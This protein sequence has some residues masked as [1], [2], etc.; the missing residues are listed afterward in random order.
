VKTPIKTMTPRKRKEV[1]TSTYAGRFAVRL[2]TLREKTKMTAQEAAGRI[3]VSLVTFYDWE[4]GR[5]IPNLARFPRISE[6]YKLRKVKDLLP[7][8]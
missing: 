3:G 8:E 6:I 5:K 2:K 7:N 1:D 4:G